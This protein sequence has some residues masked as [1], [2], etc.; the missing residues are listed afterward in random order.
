MM[1]AA[2]GLAVAD[3][4]TESVRLRLGRITAA[5][6][7][8]AGAGPLTLRQ[9]GDNGKSA[10]WLQPTRPESGDFLVLL[11]RAPSKGTWA[12]A[13]SLVLPDGPLNAP[14]GGVRVINLA[15]LDVRIVIGNDKRLLRAARTHSRAAPGAGETGEK[16]LVMAPSGC[17]SGR[18]VP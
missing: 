13:K 4:K 16:A 18:V 10:P 12:E 7:A 5:V 2:A 14:A 1:I 9:A 17:A 8:P 3:K 15:P 6:K 11:W